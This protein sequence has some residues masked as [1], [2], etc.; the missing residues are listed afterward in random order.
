MS[1]RLCL[2]RSQVR[3]NGVICMHCMRHRAAAEVSFRRRTWLDRS[4]VPSTS[5]TWVPFRTTICKWINKYSDEVAARMRDSRNLLE[6]NMF[7]LGVGL[8]EY[9]LLN[10]MQ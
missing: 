9:V 2:S 5:V 10:Q 6:I 8:N 4:P 1:N 7:L 3:D